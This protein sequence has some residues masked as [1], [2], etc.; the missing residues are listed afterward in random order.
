MDLFCRF[1]IPYQSEA[2]MTPRLSAFAFAFAL[3]LS[4]LPAGAEATRAE[5]LDAGGR[6]EASEGANRN[7]IFF[8]P[9]ITLV[10]AAFPLTPTRVALT[11]ERTL[12]SPGN[13]FLWQPG[14]FFGKVERKR[15][16]DGEQLD[17]VTVAQYGTTQFLG[18]RHYF[19]RG[20]RGFYLQGSGA[21]SLNFANAEW[22]GDPDKASGMVAGVGALGYLGYRWT[23]VFFD[24]GG[25][26]QAGGGEIENAQGKEL[27]IFRPG[28]AL[29]INLGF[30]F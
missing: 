1:S 13:S 17:D 5:S 28:F 22:E 29:D 10:T 16:E 7:H 26:F 2:A 23:H 19:G 20:Y 4:L 11:Y 9:I 25:G 30:G 14:I 18:W 15:M 3:Q 24:V 27:T 12:P 6:A 8:H 21:A